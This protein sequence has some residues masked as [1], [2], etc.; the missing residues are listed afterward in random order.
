MYFFEKYILPTHK[1]QKTFA[2]KSGFRR[3]KPTLNLMILDFSLI[4]NAKKKIKKNEANFVNYCQQAPEF[5]SV[6]F[7]WLI[8]IF[9]IKGC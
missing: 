3:T 8:F 1:H 2:N 5:I 4:S 7:S 6:Y 9:D